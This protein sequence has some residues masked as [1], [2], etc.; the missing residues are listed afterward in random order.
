MSKKKQKTNS[1][2]ND[3]MKIQV[4]LQYTISVIAAAALIGGAG[5]LSWAVCTSRIWYGTE[6]LYPV[7]TWV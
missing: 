1:S 3:S 5:V 7:L 4:M 2:R 6:M